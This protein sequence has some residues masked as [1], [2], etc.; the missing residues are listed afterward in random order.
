MKYPSRSIHLLPLISAAEAGLLALMLL[1]P[2]FNPAWAGQSYI[3]E[4]KLTGFNSTTNDFFGNAVAIS[5]DTAVVGAWQDRI[6]ANTL[7]G[8]AY[9]FVRSNA[10]WLLQQQLVVSNGVPG[11]RFGSSVAMDGDTIAVGARGDGSYGAV[12]IYTR[13]GTNWLL[14][15]KLDP[16]NS[17]SVSDFGWSVSLSGDTVLIGAPGASSGGS[18]YVY[19]RSNSVWTPQAVLS[20]PVAVFNNGFG[21]SVSLSTNT[22]LVGCYKDTVSGRTEQGS[23]Y[24]FTRTGT[25]WNFQA[26]LS[27][28]DGLANDWFGFSVALAGDTAICGEH[29]DTVSAKTQCGSASIFVRSGATWSFTQ[30]LV[31]PDSSANDN[32][33]RSLAVSGDILFVGALLD[34][35]LP[36]SGTGIDQGS[37]YVFTRSNGVWGWSQKLIAFDR[38]NSDAFSSALAVDGHSAIIGAHLDDF[39]TAV[40]QGSAHIYKVL[41]YNWVEQKVVS[42]L[43]NS[44]YYFGSDV[45]IDGTNAI[46][47]AA[48]D[49]VE[50]SDHTRPGSAY[51]FTRVA[52]TWTN[53]QRL[54]SPA[55]VN[56][57]NFGHSVSISGDYLV[58][59]APRGLVSGLTNQSHAYVFFKSDTNWVMQAT[60]AVPP[61]TDYD[62]FGRSVAIYA[63]TLV[64][65]AARA[66]GTGAAY[67]YVRSGTNWNLQATLSAADGVAGD[68]FGSAVSLRGE[69]AVIG[70]QFDDVTTN[71]AQGSVYVFVRS[72]TT[73]SQQAKLVA[74]DGASGDLFGGSVSLS[75]DTVLIGAYDAGGDLDW[76]GAAYVYTRS[77]TTWSFQQKLLPPI[78]KDDATFGGSV[79]VSDDLAIVGAWGHVNNS[80]YPGEA[81]VFVRENGQWTLNTNL[82]ASDGLP[83]DG[84]GFS[85]AVNGDCLA[86][87]ARF[88]DLA[89]TGL[90]E[91]AVYFYLNLPPA[92]AASAPPIFLLAPTRLPNGFFQFNFTNAPGRSFSALASTNVALPASNWT[93]LGA[94]TEISPGQFQFTDAQAT[95]G[96]YRFYRV[97]SP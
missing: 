22:A 81:F 60:L 39:G 35:V 16:T 59:G 44:S 97:R 79:A 55:P 78:I 43:T 66:S 51:V 2:G 28:P 48:A 36:L 5:G 84:F 42:P 19:T 18:A 45:A 95:N 83:G 7:Q 40:N 92:P 26:Q 24:V 90:D 82:T 11:Q 88:A 68:Y 62:E 17:V 94:P 76:R 87:G 33:G 69:T 34:D 89:Q 46:I 61:T 57:E 52:S 21:Y 74:G 58:I 73:W 80:T 75:D 65:G 8:S 37:A 31:A 4:A 10:D 9:V 6:G 72:G 64:V 1:S 53:R 32:F 67:V 85:V 15:Q 63:D 93:A 47:G 50:G 23:A 77:G 27:A 3:R 54:I 14:Q 71:A 20:A 86:V 25:N 38:A 30:K 96:P 13:S 91:G 12:F 70:A 56:D 41:S 29:R 49:S